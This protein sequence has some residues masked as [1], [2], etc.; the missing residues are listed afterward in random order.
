MVIIINLDH[1]QKKFPRQNPGTFLN[2]TY[3]CQLLK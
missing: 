3:E 2:D 1:T